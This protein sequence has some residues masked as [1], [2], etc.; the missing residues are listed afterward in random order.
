MSLHVDVPTTPPRSFAYD[1]VRTSRICSRL[2]ATARELSLLDPAQHL[3]EWARH[4]AAI[5]RHMEDSAL[6]LQVPDLSTDGI[7]PPHHGPR[8]SAPEHEGVAPLT[9]RQSE[10]ARLIARGFTNAQIA[11]ALVVTPGTAANHVEHILSRLGCGNRA[12]I[13]AWAAEHH[14]LD[15][16]SR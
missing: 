16:D 12:Q 3:E 10:V 6:Q 11:E 15:G 8:R 5:A 13:A 2:A 7:P 14:L 9:E 4:A 1:L